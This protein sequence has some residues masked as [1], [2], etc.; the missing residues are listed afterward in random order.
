MKLI[1]IS[2]GVNKAKQQINEWNS[3]KPMKSKSVCVCVISIGSMIDHS[4]GIPFY[5]LPKEAAKWRW[6]EK[7]KKK[8]TEIS[9]KGDIQLN[10]TDKQKYN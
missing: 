7:F 4:K 8:N 9:V 1:Y 5:K 10:L 2:H 6:K 3:K